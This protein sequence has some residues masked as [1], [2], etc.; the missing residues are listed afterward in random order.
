M[1]WLVDFFRT[2]PVIPVFL[3]M[4][5][6]F[7]LGKLKY[8][9][10]VLGPVAATLIVGV[11]IGQMKIVV[12]DI[13]KTVF[14]LL[15][16][17]SIGYGV[18]PQ[19]FRS[20]RGPGFR[21]AGFAVLVALICSGLVLLAAKIMGYDNGIA[22]GLYAGSQTASACLGMVAD[23]VR[24]M[25]L[26]LERRQY[27]LMI[28]PGCYAVTYVFGTIGT[29]WYLSSVAPKTMGGLDR[30]MADVADI[31][32]S[33]DAGGPVLEPGQ[34]LAARPVAFRAYT[35]A[36]AYF[37][38]PRTVA[39]VEAMLGQGDCR[40]F[41]ERARIGGRIVE[42]DADTIINKGDTLVL[43]ARFGNLVDMG[44][45][46]GPEIAD[47]E[48]LNFGAERTPV[49]V[50]VKGA[51]GMTFGQLRAKDYMD[52]VMVA[53]ITRNGVA[54]PLKNMVEL[55]P[56]DVVTLVGWPCDVARAAG[57]I[58]YADRQTDT[59]DMVFVGLGIAAGCVL[60]ALA[61][62]VNGIPLSL[63]TSVGALISGLALG[64]LRNRTPY[65]G[66]IPSAVL[67]LLNNLGITMFIAVIGLS[68]GASFMNGLHKAGVAIFGVGAVCTI[69]G[70]VISVYIGRKWFHFSRPEVLGCVAGARCSVAALGA[71]QQTLHSDVPNLGY[72]VTY[73]IANIALVLSSLLVLFLA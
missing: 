27:L 35:A 58:G 68:A 21:Q 60:G 3:T 17:F 25:P 57:H 64:W 39:D 73:A 28:I 26:D 66:H 22:T 34:I 51:A 62:K 36:S 54:I 9:N 61:I 69:L 8:K 29:A 55:H 70:L 23:T 1:D 72:T 63:G 42:P 6:G 49:T 7:W 32:Q 47:P 43:G 20:F 44:A 5:L 53:S 19:F 33:M 37:D 13:L 48:L 46:I 41:V 12:P 52:R 59:T 65:F 31:E 16:L 71:I 38:T 11:I 67:W 56:G 30:V 45:K 2:N 10:F 50:S 18:G 24:E 4:G 15:F 14:F 40:A